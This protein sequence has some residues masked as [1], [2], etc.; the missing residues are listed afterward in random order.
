VSTTDYLNA[1][2]SYL[3][4]KVPSIFIFEETHLPDTPVIRKKIC[5]FLG[6]KN[7]LSY[8]TKKDLVAVCAMLIGCV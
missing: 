7:L 8:V 4:G 2:Y 1:K 6:K 3:E 5:Q